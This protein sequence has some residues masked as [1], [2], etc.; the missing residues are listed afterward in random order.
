VTEYR[1]EPS[2]RVPSYF[3]PQGSSSGIAFVAQSPGK[4]ELEQGVPLVGASG[5]LLRECCGLANIPWLAT[6]RGNVVGFKPP[7][8]DFNFF[9]GKKAE[10]GGKDYP[11][12]PIKSGQYLKPIWFDELARLRDE[13]LVV[14]PAIAVPLGN[15]ALW[16]L[17]KQ[18]GITKYRGS[19]MESTLVPGLKVVPSW[20]PAAVLRA[21]DKKI[22]LILDLIKAQAESKFPEIRL[23]PREIWIYPEVDDLW[24]W[25]KMYASPDALCSVDIETPHS[26]VACIGFAFSK[27]HA[28][29]VPFWSDLRPGHS[30]WR[31]LEEELEAWR[32]VEHMLETYP[33]LGQN[34]YAYDNWYLLREMGLISRRMRHDTMIQHHCHMPEMTKGLG[35]LTSIYCNLPAYK[36]LRPRGIKAEKRDE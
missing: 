7:A 1:H 14:Q 17:T 30:Y 16:A 13:L 19:V 29:V 36:T 21:Y 4:T 18:S 12:P 31:T 23:E 10:V 3:P 33:V 9:C 2:K 32:F 25:E 35:Y 8:N 22:D 5:K 26:Q 24:Q 6:Y 34:Y 20:H 11:L 27:S 15:E 28:L